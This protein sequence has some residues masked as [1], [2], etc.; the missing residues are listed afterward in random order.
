M[1][2]VTILRELWHRRIL[3]GLVA[4]A[5]IL[6]GVLLTYKLSWPPESRKY[7]VGVASARVFVDT[8]RSQVVDVAPRGSE[9]TG[10]RA[11]LLANL[12]TQGV[13]KETI[14]KRAGL[15]PNQ[16]VAGVESGGVLPPDLANARVDPK[17]HSLTTRLVLNPDG[18]P[19]PMFELESQGPDPAA[20]GRLATAAVEGLGTY[21]DS[22]AAAEQVPDARRL[23]VTGTGAP[24]V[25][26]DTRGP[27]RLVALGAALFVFLGG[28]ALIVLCSRLARGWR[29]AAEREEGVAAAS[30]LDGAAGVSGAA[31][32]VAAG[33]PAGR[34]LPDAGVE[35][36][37][38][39]PRAN[40][41]PLPR[42]ADAAPAR[43]DNGNGDSGRK[44][45]VE[46][47]RVESA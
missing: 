7:E 21:L 39:R 34:E 19:L 24:Q 30:D 27:R 17:A 3:V 5:A 13:V 35:S 18:L 15:R 29:A 33:A 4:A 46:S 45:G 32:S 14:A 10:A 42:Y 23:Q 2:A 47:A 12:M 9:T 28:C 38:A 36:P 6:V 25:W 16:L 11:N 31:P 44:A 37:P 41:T 43:A 40:L 26:R 22:K 8:P 20:A 1:E